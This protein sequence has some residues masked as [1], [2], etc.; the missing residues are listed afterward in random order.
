[1]S[2]LLSAIYIY[3]K[4]V[5]PLS[6]TNFLNVNCIRV[7]SLTIIML[8]DRKHTDIY[9]FHSVYSANINVYISILYTRID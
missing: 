4:T 2:V 8:Y 9:I 6:P 7:S 5:F 1:M 3:Y